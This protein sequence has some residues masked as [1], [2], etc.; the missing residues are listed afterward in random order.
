MRELPMNRL[1]PKALS[2]FRI[3]AAI[4][5]GILFIIFVALTVLIFIFDWPKWIIPILAVIL[6]IYIALMVMYVPKVRLKMWRY[7][8]NQHE[9]EL[10]YGV[11]VIKRILIPM[12]RVQHVDTSQGPILRKY[13]L[14]TVTISS[15]ATEHEI[16]ALEEDEADQ[17]RNYI[18][19]LAREAKEDV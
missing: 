4:S 2:V 9:I 17:L 16:P 13:N 11:F 10:Q 5:S 19:Q 8:V 1:S 14:A 12:V 15:A 18:S 7:E 3:N 6:I